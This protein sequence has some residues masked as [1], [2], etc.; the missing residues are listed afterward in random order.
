LVFELRLPVHVAGTSYWSCAADALA[1]LDLDVGPMPGHAGGFETSCL[2]AIAPELVRTD[3]MPPPE[4]ELQPLAGVQ[5]PGA[6]IRRPGAWEISDGRTDDS[7]RASAEIGH[8]VLDS[9]SHRI[10]RFIVDFHR[11]ADSLPAH[12]PSPNGHASTDG[13]ASH[14][15]RPALET[16]E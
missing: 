13:G 11:A 1:E 7:R 9:L 8:R 3:L 14:N 5:M 16:M 15:R 10:S 4:P 12:A 6:A 2:L